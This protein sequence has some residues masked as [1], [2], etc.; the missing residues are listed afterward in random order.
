MIICEAQEV[1]MRHIPYY[2]WVKVNSASNK[3]CE[4][5]LVAAPGIPPENTEPWTYT[6]AQTVHKSDS[7]A[8]NY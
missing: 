5:L 6:V 8:C 4:V 2:L 3:A 7:W 1:L